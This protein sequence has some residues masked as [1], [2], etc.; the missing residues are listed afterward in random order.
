MTTPTTHSVIGRLSELSRLLD[1]ATDEIA[2][3]DEEAVRA[4]Q[5]H[6]VAYAEA[7]LTAE[8]SI[9]VRKQT[10]TLRVR[11]V[12]L[13]RELAEQ[14]VRACQERIRTLRSQLEVG[15]SLNAAVRTEWTA[16]AV[17]QP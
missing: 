3:L 17:G 14:K 16:A 8:G 11:E 9:D 6:E 13:A 5:T 15:R 12:K 2:R 4:K 10:A 1:A 7:F